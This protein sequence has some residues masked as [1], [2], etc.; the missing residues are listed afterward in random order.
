M[1][2]NTRDEPRMDYYEFKR[3]HDEWL[4]TFADVRRNVEDSHQRPAPVPS[5]QPPPEDAK[6]DS[7]LEDAATEGYLAPE[8]PAPAS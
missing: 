5:R 8:A 3:K 4:E 1:A 2:S 7:P 6:V